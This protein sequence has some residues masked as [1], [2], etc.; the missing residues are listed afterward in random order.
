[1]TSEILREIDERRNEII[2]LSR[3]LVKFDTTV[4]D[5]PGS[6]PAQEEECQQYIASALQKT[7]FQIDV[8]E[9]DPEKLRKYPTFVPGQ[10]FSHRP[11]VVGILRGSGHGKS[12]ILNG[13]IDVVPTG[14]IDR[15]NHDPWGAEI[16]NNRIY[17][18]GSSDMKSG[19]AAMIKAVE[20][21]KGANINLRGDIIVQTVTDEE[22]NGMGTIACI[23]KG[24]KG[25]AGIDPEPTGSHE[26][27]TCCRGILMGKVTVTGRSG[28]ADIN[29]RHWREGGGVNAI[30]KAMLIL[31]AMKNLE[32]EWR[33]RIDKTH[34]LLP[35]P[36][37]HPTLIHGGEFWTTI[38][39]KCEITIDVQYLPGNRDS[40]GYGGQVKNEFETAILSASRS[41][42]WLLEHPPSFDWSVDLPPWEVDT[43]HPI[44]QTILESAAKSTVQTKVAGLPSWIDAAFLTIYGNT[45]SISFGPG[46][47]LKAHTVDEC[48]EIDDV[49]KATKV[50]ALTIA[51]WCG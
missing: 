1:M 32:A 17:G 30:D 27:W 12:L 5:P 7:G 33:G 18:R 4:P 25:D 22:L 20:F 14:P 43:N 26:V 24:Y 16:E 34:L 13:H 44:V 37:V 40:N 49:I 23:E 19:I 35:I 29:Q 46:N 38:P 41:D 42:P 3:K 2:D 36:E 21:V 39:E 10:N 28:H 8:W 50:M 48:V 47:P 51:K 15:W 9:P 45:P 31:G 11:V 6:P